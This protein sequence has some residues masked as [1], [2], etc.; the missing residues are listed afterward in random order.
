MYCE[1]PLPERQTIGEI[2][3]VT[4]HRSRLVAAL[5]VIAVLMQAVW[6]LVAQLRAAAPQMVQVICTVHG[7]MLMPVGDTPEAPTAPSRLPAPCA[8][9]SAVSVAL[10]SALPLHRLAEAAADA[11]ASFAYTP[12]IRPAF[13]TPAR[14][15]APPAY[16]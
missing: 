7:L 1:T 15:R 3:R 16:S 4:L 9:C 6:P 12:V 13:D 2:R 5:A 11:V 8:M 10:V 14:P